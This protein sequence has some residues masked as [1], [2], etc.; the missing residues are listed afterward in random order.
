[1]PATPVEEQLRALDRL[2]R[3][4][5]VRWI[6]LS[7]ETP[8]GVMTFL[9]AAR[10]HGLARVVSVQNA[11][12]LLNR[13]ADSGLAKCSG[14]RRWDCSPTARSPSATSPASI[15]TACRRAR[16]W[17]SSRTSGARYSKPGVAPAVTAYCGLAASRGITPVQLAL[18]FVASRPFV[19]STIVGA[20]SRAQL[21]ENLDAFATPL[22]R[23]T[24]EAIDAIHLQHTNPP[25]IKGDS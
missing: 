10:E 17:A 4:G 6:G 12:N 8:W 18:G 2:V 19:A 1:M 21:A 16:A 25:L 7:N 22:D 3:A 13:V 15:A 20:T 23:E 14:G 11:Y 9:A 24:L 5:K